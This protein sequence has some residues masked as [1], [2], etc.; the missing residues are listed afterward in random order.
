MLTTLTRKLCP[1][2]S[3]AIASLGCGKKIADAETQS[4]RSRDNQELPSTHVLRLDGSQVSRKLFFM[5]EDVNF[6]VPDRLRVLIGQTTGKQVEI[7]Y[8]VN[9]YDRDDFQ[10]KCTYTASHNPSEMILDKCVDYHDYDFGDVSGHT[11]GLRQNDAIEMKF[12]GANASDM[13]VDAIYSMKW[14]VP[15]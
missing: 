5:P 10:F 3:L 9:E 7:S 8:E 12:T 4:G 13:V 1:L 6:K 15:N 14:I 11:F 2:L